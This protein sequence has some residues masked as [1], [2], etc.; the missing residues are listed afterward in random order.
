MPRRLAA[1]L[2]VVLAACS[3][4]TKAAKGPELH[5]ED[6]V[7]AVAAVEAK[8]PGAK[9]TE[10]NMAPEG[11]NLF[12]ITSPGRESSFLY[13]AGALNAPTPEQPA[14]GEAFAVTGVPL[15]QAA[16]VAAFITKEFKGSTITGVAL[17]V[18]KPNGLVW[19]VRSQSVKGGLLNS[20]FS[21]DG[22]I[23][24]TLPAK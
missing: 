1:L 17:L 5:I 9:Y 6:V 22:K 4:S 10:I 21:P 12:V 7:A 18:V 3:S 2:L 24:S 8:L 16:K 19:A 23:I 13:A 11:V 14:E 20:L 15:D